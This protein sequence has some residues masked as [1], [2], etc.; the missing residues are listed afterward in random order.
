MQIAVLGSKNAGK[1]SIIAYYNI[2]AP[3]I[4]FVEF[5]DSLYP[6]YKLG[7]YDYVFIVYDITDK[8]S[9]N[10][11]LKWINLCKKYK[12]LQ[13]IVMANKCD[14]N[15]NLKYIYNPTGHLLINVSA[16]TGE[17]LGSVV[18]LI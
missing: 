7:K 11:I 8:K 5:A 3:H 16:I 12:S 13:Y 10:S 4:E 17:G 15:I 18:K 6:R 2:N 9:R 14:I 1:S